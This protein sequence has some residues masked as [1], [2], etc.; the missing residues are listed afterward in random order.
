MTVNLETNLIHLS[1]LVQEIHA[2][3]NVGL[4]ASGDDW[5]ENSWRKGGPVESGCPLLRVPGWKTSLWSEESWGDLPQDIEGRQNNLW[6]ISRWTNCLD[7]FRTVTFSSLLRLQ[8]CTIVFYNV[9]TGFLSLS[10]RWS[11]RILHRSISVL[12]PKIWLPGCW[13]TTLCTDCPSRESCPTPGW[14]KPPPRSPQPWPMNSPA[15]EPFGSPLPNTWVLH[16]WGWS[17]SEHWLQA[18]HLS[19]SV[20]LIYQNRLERPCWWRNHFTWVFF[21]A[22]I[23]SHFVNLFLLSFILLHFL[24]CKYFTVFV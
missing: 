19:T 3:W 21:S 1:F 22:G 8:T 5:G 6:L 4:L 11:I 12:E 15:N 17:T 18:W 16:M 23:L 13:S 9:C 24:A 10:S 2:V 14:S 20:Q 7:S